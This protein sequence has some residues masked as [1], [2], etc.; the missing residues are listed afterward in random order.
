MKTFPPDH[1]SLLTYGNFNVRGFIE[2]YSIIRAPDWSEL[3]WDES[4]NIYSWSS[5][6]LHPDE[7][8]IHDLPES[9]DK[10]DIVISY[11]L[12]RIVKG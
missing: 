1:Q 9:K 5:E 12:I 8:L 2:K 4:A 3:K 7:P 6:V 10:V 11:N